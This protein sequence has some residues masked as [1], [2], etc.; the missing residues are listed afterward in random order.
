MIIIILDMKHV[1]HICIAKVT[2]L[3]ADNRKESDHKPRQSKMC[4]S[5]NELKEILVT[6]Q[7]NFIPYQT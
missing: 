3:L 6:S 5:K 4:D 7:T 2:Y 1:L